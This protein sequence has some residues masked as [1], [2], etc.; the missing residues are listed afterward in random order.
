[1]LY[2]ERAAARSPLDRY[3]EALAD[4]GRAVRLDPD[5]A[6]ASGDR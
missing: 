6:S 3:G 2:L 1:M 5:V 4:Y